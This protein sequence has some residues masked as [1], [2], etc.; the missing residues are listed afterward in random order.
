MNCH[1]SLKDCPCKIARYFLPIPCW[2]IRKARGHSMQIMVQEDGPKLS[3]RKNVIACWLVFANL[4]CGIRARNHE[5]RSS[6]SSRTRTGQLGE[7]L[8]LICCGTIKRKVHRYLPTTSCNDLDSPICKPLHKR[9]HPEFSAHLFCLCYT[10]PRS[11]ST[12]WG[13]SLLSPSPT[14]RTF[15]VRSIL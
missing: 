11:R 5:M 1:D 12:P 13:T 14:V 10:P 3:F 2:P 7:T 9:I 4:A 8:N 6:S 15:R